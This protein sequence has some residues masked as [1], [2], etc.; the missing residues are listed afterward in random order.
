MKAVVVVCL[1]VFLSTTIS[2]WAHGS[3]G[4]SSSG[5][6][7]AGAGGGNGPGHG[8]ANASSMGVGHGSVSALGHAN[9]HAT[10]SMFAGHLHSTKSTTAAHH[11]KAHHRSAVPTQLARKTTLPGKRKGFIDNLPAG[12]ESKLDRGK[13]LPLGWKT[14]V[15]SGAVTTDT[16]TTT[17]PSSPPGREIQADR[18]R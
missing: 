4:G 17:N 11:S 12:L 13:T 2:G 5:S 8:G 10:V 15:G 14:K 6:G 18:G 9:Q 1:A 16:D 7:G 3:G